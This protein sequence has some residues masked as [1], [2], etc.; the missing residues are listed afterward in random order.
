MILV[1]AVLI[2]LPFTIF[3]VTRG[4]PTLTRGATGVRV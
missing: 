2:A 4:N 3:A 1:A